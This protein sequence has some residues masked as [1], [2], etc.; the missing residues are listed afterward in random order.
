MQ[1]KEGGG[2]GFIMCWFL[3]L[4]FWSIPLIILEYALGRKSGQMHINTFHKYLG[5][6]GAWKGAFIVMV[7]LAVS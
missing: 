3:S 1:I 4:I 7:Q 5:N 2:G 6:Y